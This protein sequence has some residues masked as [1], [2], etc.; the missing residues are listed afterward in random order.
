M[1]HLLS[2]LVV[3]AALISGSAAA[4]SA[5]PPPN[6][7]CV[8]GWHYDDLQHHCVKDGLSDGAA[9]R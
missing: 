7:H 6:V 8:K 1:R 2:A 5:L 4:A 3:A 9:V